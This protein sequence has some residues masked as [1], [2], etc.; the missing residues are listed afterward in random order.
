MRSGMSRVTKTSAW[1]RSIGDGAREQRDRD[2]DGV[3]TQRGSR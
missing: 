1:M 3:L 2:I